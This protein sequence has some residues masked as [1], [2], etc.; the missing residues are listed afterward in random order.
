[1]PRFQVPVDLLTD[2]DQIRRE[3]RA[4]DQ[5]SEDPATADLFRQARGNRSTELVELPWLDADRRLDAASSGLPRGPGSWR[6]SRGLCPCGRGRLGPAG[7]RS[8]VP[9]MAAQA[10]RIS[11]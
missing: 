2:V 3:S 10:S 4:L 1:M 7:Y 8:S 6:M 5:T 9:G 11:V